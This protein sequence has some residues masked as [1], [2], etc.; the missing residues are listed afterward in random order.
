[1]LS[2]TPAHAL[3]TEAG[4]WR[5]AGQLQAGDYLRSAK[6][7][8]RLDSTYTE[9]VSPT[10]VISYELEGGKAY[11]VGEMPVVV[12]GT[13][14]LKTIKEAL[15]TEFSVFQNRIFNL[16]LKTAERAELYKDFVAGNQQL[17][18]LLKTEEGL[19][20]WKGLANTTVRTNIS[21]LNRTK[22]WLSEGATLSHSSG[23]T[24]LQKAGVEVAEI[25]NGQLLPT[26]Y[27]SAGTAVGDVTDGYQVVKNGNTWGVKRVPDTAPYS[28]S[29]LT[30]L[31][32]HPQ[33]HVLE[34]HGHDVCDEALIKRANYGIAP[35]GSTIGNS[36]SPVRPQYSS[37]FETSDQLKKALQNTNPTSSAWATKQPNK[38]GGWDVTHELTD[39]T[40]YGKGVPKFTNSFQKMNKVLASYA[41]TS[42]GKFELVTMYPTK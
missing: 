4:E 2:V 38:Y 30:E 1:M 26:K 41:E 20:A 18:N 35:D 23:Q 3:Q 22:V 24:V 39:G 28:P 8:V 42:P 9:S 25:K 17:R 33:A 10:A 32:Q 6:G 31:T 12:A 36:S 29:E 5:A 11:V 21:W 27:E 16:G 34:R 19:K 37:K 13:C 14:D 7:V 15:G 40:F